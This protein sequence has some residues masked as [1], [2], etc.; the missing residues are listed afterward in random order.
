[1]EVRLSAGCGMPG[2]TPHRNDRIQ[3][4]A[5]ALG[6]GPDPDWEENTSPRAQER[7]AVSGEAGSL[8]SPDRKP[9]LS[10]HGHSLGAA[11]AGHGHSLLPGL[12]SDAVY[13]HS[14]VSR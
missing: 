10:A 14:L 12:V 8:V 7:S 1:M 6:Q 2:R 3:N 9:E 13:R 5:S 11:V 4:P